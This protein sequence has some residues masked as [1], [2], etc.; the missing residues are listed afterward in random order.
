MKKLLIIIISILIMLL[1]CGNAEYKAYVLNNV[2]EFQDA[3]SDCQRL[4]SE[5]TGLVLNEVEKLDYEW[6]SGAKF[7]IISSKDHLWSSTDAEWF[8]TI[9]NV[10]SDH[11]EQLISYWT[12]MIE[13]EPLSSS[14][15][16]YYEYPMMENNSIAIMLE[17]EYNEKYGN[18][19]AAAIEMEEMNG[20]CFLW[21]YTMKAAFYKQ[22]EMEPFFKQK[23]IRGDLFYEEWLLPEDQ[24]IPY[25]DIL[26]WSKDIIQETFGLPEEIIELFYFDS[27]FCMHFNS[28]EDPHW[29][30]KAWLFV[31]CGGRSFWVPCIKLSISREGRLEYCVI[32]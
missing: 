24:D 12:P 26:S 18:V 13:A 21:D 20:P 7:L 5:K 17:N 32:D 4:F 30:I 14:S 11:L 22:W 29:E 19:D 6:S 3:L 1:S 10:T 31:E 15:Y 25:E 2:V 8:I 23:Y 9:R 28:S 27:R 16:T